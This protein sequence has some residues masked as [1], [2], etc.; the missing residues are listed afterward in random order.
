MSDGLGLRFLLDLQF[1]FE[2]RLPSPSGGESSQLPWVARCSVNRSKWVAIATGAISLL[3]GVAYLAVVQLL[4]WRGEM[5][6]APLLEWLPSVWL[7]IGQA[8]ARIF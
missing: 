7:V 5:V 1:L 4:D 3:L 6:P 8:C 2:F